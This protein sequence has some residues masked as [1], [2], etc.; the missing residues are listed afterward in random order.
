MIP[1][2]V[3]GPPKRRITMLLLLI[4]TGAVPPVG[5]VPAPSVRGSVIFRH[6]CGYGCPAG[7]AAENFEPPPSCSTDAEGEMRCQVSGDVD[8]LWFEFYRVR[9]GKLLRQAGKVV[10]GPEEEVTGGGG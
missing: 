9:G 4:V 2:V 5:N 1:T 7:K 3:P 8:E 6:G 10:R